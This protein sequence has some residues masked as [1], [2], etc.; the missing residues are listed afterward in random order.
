MNTS[1]YNWL[2]KVEGKK[3]GTTIKNINKERVRQGYKPKPN[4]GLL[5]VN[6]LKRI[7]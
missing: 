5:T 7:K 6:A 1:L 3:V 4:Y 2:D